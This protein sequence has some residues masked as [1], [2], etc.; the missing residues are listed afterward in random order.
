MII[1]VLI[2]VCHG[3]LLMNS[4]FLAHTH[5]LPKSL[6]QTTNVVGAILVPDFYS[7]MNQYYWNKPRNYSNIFSYLSDDIIELPPNIVWHFSIENINM[8]HKEW[9]PLLKGTKIKSIQLFHNRCN[10]YY[11]YNNGL[12]DIGRELLDILSDNQYILDLSHV[13]DK[14][15]Y[16]ICRIYDG[17]ISISHCGCS[18]LYR[19]RYNRTNS[20]SQNT[21]VKL[22]N[23]NNIYFGIAFL[24]DIICEV[25]N[26]QEDC[27]IYKNI[28]DQITLF[29]EIIGN[30]RVMLGPDYFN[31]EYFSKKF[32]TALKIPKELY[33]NQGFENLRHI[34]VKN[35][36]TS[37]E[38]DNVFFKNGMR[39]ISNILNIC[40]QEMSF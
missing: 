13:N 39:L 8:V 19:E 15:L 18:D 12:T 37:Y 21:L 30:E 32:N 4:I 9:L 28:A 7:D 31:M 38:I 36:L 24:N 27:I 17:L 10:S 33:A 40:S 3:D 20:I 29:T 25:E 22:S 5:Y 26:E 34:L 16:E 6:L 2:A 35:N 14:H 23:M 1:T 11:S